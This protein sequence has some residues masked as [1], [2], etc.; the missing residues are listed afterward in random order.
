MP[1][2]LCGDTGRLGDAECPEMRC[3]L[4]KELDKYDARWR[5][6]LDI[7]ERQIADRDAKIMSLTRLLQEKDLLIEMIDPGAKA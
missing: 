7:K 6:L 2:K 4:T 3:Q 1:C 5:A